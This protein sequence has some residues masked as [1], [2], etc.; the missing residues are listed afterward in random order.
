MN[1]KDKLIELVKKCSNEYVE[2]EI[3]NTTNLIKDLGY[4]S[5]NLIQLIVEI[6]TEFDVEITDKM[7]SGDILTNFQNLLECIQEI[8]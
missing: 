5:L 4:S 2:M 3:T 6:E 1:R 7:L 8:D